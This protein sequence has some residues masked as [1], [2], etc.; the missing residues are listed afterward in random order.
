MPSILTRQDF[1][2]ACSALGVN[3]SADLSEIKKAHRRAIRSVHPDTYPAN[4][5]D[6]AKK[7]AEFRKFQE[8][9]EV[10]RECLETFGGPPKASPTMPTPS[11]STD[12]FFAS[13]D[14][15]FYEFV[16]AQ[17]AKQRSESFREF[18]PQ[19][20]AVMA[21]RLS[22][23]AAGYP[24]IRLVRLIDT[25]TQLHGD[26][27]A[28]NR[29]TSTLQVQQALAAVKAEINRL[30]SNPRK[31]ILDDLLDGILAHPHHD[32]NLALAGEVM[33]LGFRTNRRVH[34]ITRDEVYAHYDRRLK[35]D[36][37]RALKSTDLM[38]N[39]DDFLPKD[40]ERRLKSQGIYV[41]PSSI[42]LARTPL[43]LPLLKNSYPITYE[44]QR[45]VVDGQEGTWPAGI[46]ELPYKVFTYNSFPDGPLVKLIKELDAIDLKLYFRLTDGQRMVAE[47]I[48]LSSLRFGVQFYV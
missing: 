4:D 13:R 39:R 34:P 30:R 46:I 5:P 29:P 15:D 31:A 44:F 10:L 22:L 16:R 6:A 14:P 19:L 43:T 27:L 26:M 17:N 24:T 20:S 1:D 37:V 40:L 18:V 11:F 35:G 21:E 25:F 8:A 33:S 28:V 2:S 23:V 3:Q 38:L 36:S 48:N 32:S 41:A 12:P 42:K 47:G 9:Y 7:T 45:M